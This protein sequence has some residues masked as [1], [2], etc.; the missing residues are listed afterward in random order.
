M[1]TVPVFGPTRREGQSLRLSAVART[2]LM[3]AVLLAITGC[4]SASTGT[5]PTHPSVTKVSTKSPNTI[6]TTNSVTA[7]Q[8]LPTPTITL[9]TKGLPTS[10]SQWGVHHLV[11]GPDGNVWFTGSWDTN[12]APPDSSVTHGFVGRI[13]VEGQITLF[14]KS[15]T[16]VYRLGAITP[17]PDGSLWFS[18]E[19]PFP[20]NASHGTWVIGQITPSGAITM[21]PSALGSVKPLSIGGSSGDIVAGS[22]GDLWLSGA[23]GNP[24]GTIRG[25]IWRLTP[26]G[27][28]TIFTKGLPN[29]GA[30]GPLLAGPGGNIW[31]ALGQ[32]TPSGVVTSFS[33]SLPAGVGVGVLAIGP[34]GNLWFTAQSGPRGPGAIGRITTAGTVTL[35]TKGMPSGLP[36]DIVAGP[37][38][39]L[40]FTLS[41]PAAIGRITPSGTISV[42][43]NGLSSSPSALL[44]NLVAG[45]DG[46]LWFTVQTGAGPGAIGCITPAGNI[47]LFTNGLL[48]GGQPGF[49]LTAGAGGSLWFTDSA[50]VNGSTVTAIGRIIP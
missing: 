20:N 38:G 47:S 45:A 28:A 37:D 15:L 1:I 21:F 29:S 13:T 32:I 14:T 35:F 5:K 27:I 48:A 42:F 43:T 22:E 3:I 41:S 8:N 30:P 26:S 39:N 6:S 44:G 11:A 12:S 9:F 19:L 10:A 7:D 33:S 49:N 50:F 46:N 17:S 23:I 24:Y 4:G 40:W 36:G 2:C 34:D 18:E 25:A 16:P 31:F